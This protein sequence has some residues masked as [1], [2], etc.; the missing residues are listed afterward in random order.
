M[1]QILLVILFA[2]LFTA[3]Q[4]GGGSNSSAGSTQPINSAVAFLD[5]AEQ[6][7]N[8][9]GDPFQ[10]F[11]Q[12]DVLEK[13]YIGNEIGLK[14]SET[15]LQTIL[16]KRTLLTNR[17]VD[18]LDYAIQELYKGEE[19]DYAVINEKI[20]FLSNK[21]TD[22]RRTD[23]QRKGELNNVRN[24][25]NK[26]Y[27]F[28]EL[29]KKN[30]DEMLFDVSTHAETL[31]EKIEIINTFLESNPNT[32]SKRKLSNNRGALVLDYCSAQRAKD[33]DLSLG[34]Y[35]DVIKEC[36]Q[37]AYWVEDS[38]QKEQLAANEQELRDQQGNLVLSL[39]A[40]YTDPY[41]Y[42]S[43]T[44]RDLF[45]VVSN[46]SYCDSLGQFLLDENK[47]VALDSVKQGLQQ[48]LNDKLIAKVE[49]D[50]ATSD[51]SDLVT[52]NYQIEENNNMLGLLSN[53]EAKSKVEELQETLMS[54]REALFVERCERDKVLAKKLSLGELND[55][56][57]DYEAILL[58]YF[59][60]SESKKS[61]AAC[62]NELKAYREQVM[63]RELT[64]D[65][66]KM[67]VAFVRE[68]KKS[69]KR[70]HEVCR[71]ARDFIIVNDSDWK[72]GRRETE[73]EVVKQ[74]YELEILLR[75]K[76]GA[77]CKK[78]TRYKGTMKAEATL[79]PA[80]GVTLTRK[81]REGLQKL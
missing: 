34:L 28:V 65:L 59:K 1:K 39:C 15:Q 40:N 26:M 16:E 64:V 55:L 51:R 13:N 32:L 22:L 48:S 23:I 5:Q 43:Q 8:S 30:V 60:N 2:L 56:L 37:Y 81:G 29:D 38:L 78:S 58:Q 62:L 3:C 44:Q 52:L 27:E 53:V 67:K 80:G 75:A 31:D 68:L 77:L 79:D 6:L 54:K 10:L 14:A 45:S 72:K 69:I 49:G 47:A 76:S 19:E 18:W 73:G 20:N 7:L 46:L 11:E 74:I 61:V 71:V 4:S 57:V 25:L 33:Q 9:S 41:N 66:E 42:E 36:K 50:V 63:S 21:I 70:K 35:N 17:Q 24:A 12:Y